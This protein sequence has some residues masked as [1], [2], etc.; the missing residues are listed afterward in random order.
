MSR[1]V[2]MPWPCKCFLF[3]LFIAGSV[4]GPGLGELVLAVPVLTNDLLGVQPA[5][6]Q[7]RALGQGLAAAPRGRSGVRAEHSLPSWGQRVF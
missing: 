1:A 7:T 2:P 5:R 4:G 6:G 3:W